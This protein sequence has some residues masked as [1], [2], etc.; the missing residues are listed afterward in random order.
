M[1]PPAAFFPRREAAAL[2]MVPPSAGAHYWHPQDARTAETW[3]QSF[4]AH[5]LDGALLATPRQI[6]KP[7]TPDFYPAEPLLKKEKPC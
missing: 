5:Y 3:V 6:G 7:D 1:K 2:Q 4:G